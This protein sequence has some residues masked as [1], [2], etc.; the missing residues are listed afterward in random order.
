MCTG[1]LS[2]IYGQSEKMD[3]FTFEMQ[4]HQQYLPR[5]ILERL[6]AQASPSQMNQ[7]QSPRMSKTNPKSRN[8]RMKPEIPAEPSIILSDLPEAPISSFGVTSK[9]LAYLEV[10][11]PQANSRIIWHHNWLRLGRRNYR[12]YART[13]GLF[14]TKPPSLPLPS[15]KQ[16][17]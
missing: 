17:R 8:Q 4:D 1:K 14:T 16:S 11:I 5:T 6:F 13:H 9:L 15:H 3:L 10:H 12:Q 2:A 7:N